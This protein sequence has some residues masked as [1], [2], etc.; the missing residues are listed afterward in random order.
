MRSPCAGWR[1]FE[2]L[3]NNFR[4]MEARAVLLQGEIAG[5]KSTAICNLGVVAST[6]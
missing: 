3:R 5:W 4:K 2:Y 6:S 1:S